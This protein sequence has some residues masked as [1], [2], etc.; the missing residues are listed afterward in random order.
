MSTDN[1][2]EHKQIS[3]ALEGAA[4][5]AFMRAVLNDLRALDLMVTQG[6]FERGV[7]RIGAEQEMFLVDSAY[8]PAPGALKI[9]QGVQDPHFTTELGLFNLESNADPQ[10][11]A[12]AGL[13]NMEAQ[14]TALFAKVR[15]TAEE[16]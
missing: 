11:F 10:P 7:S 12:G 5:R 14:L 15:K 8:H 4:R 2:H 3:G 13:R 9:L 6:S 16:L 1:T